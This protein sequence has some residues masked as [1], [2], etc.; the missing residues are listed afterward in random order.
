M[1]KGELLATLVAYGFSGRVG[2]MGG[3]DPDLEGNDVILH[4]QLPDCGYRFND[5]GSV[6]CFYPNEDAMIHSLIYDMGY[7]MEE[8]QEEVYNPAHY[9]SVLGLFHSDDG[10]FEYFIDDNPEI[11]DAIVSILKIKEEK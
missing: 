5:D 4:S 9:D 8:A 7:T 11:Y 2:P 10:W 6:D 3:E 1:N